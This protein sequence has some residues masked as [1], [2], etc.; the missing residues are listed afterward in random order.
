[1]VEID[2]F[3]HS[4]TKTQVPDPFFFFILQFNWWEKS[5]SGGGGEVREAGEHIAGRGSR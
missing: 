5:E 2:A 4:L 3:W 1:M